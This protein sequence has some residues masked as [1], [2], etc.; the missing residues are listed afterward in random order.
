MPSIDRIARVIIEELSSSAISLKNIEQNQN[1]MIA[2][3]KEIIHLLE[4]IQQSFS[5]RDTSLIS[6]NEQSESNIL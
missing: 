4:Q 1:D 3:N 6:Q 2:Q 5:S